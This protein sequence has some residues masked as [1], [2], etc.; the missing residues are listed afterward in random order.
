VKRVK[1]WMTCL[2]KVK[3]WTENTLLISSD[4]R[5]PRDAAGGE[6]R[7]PVPARL[8]GRHTEPRAFLGECVRDGSLP[9]VNDLLCGG[10][11]HFDK[12]VGTDFLVQG[13]TPC[14]VGVVHDIGIV[15]MV[16]RLPVQE[17]FGVARHALQNQLQIFLEGKFVFPDLAGVGA[18]HVREPLEGFFVGAVERV[19]DPPV[20]K[21]V[22]VEASRHAHDQRRGVGRVGR[23]GAG[24][25]PLLE[26]DRALL[27]HRAEAGQQEE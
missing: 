6:F 2:G 7:A 17:D 24:E 9:L 26:K 19:G 13:E 21:E 8:V 1:V 15:L 11:A 16:K 10:E 23:V 5:S 27:R 4:K 20:V 18:G 14:T 25:A 12:V 3:C 22:G